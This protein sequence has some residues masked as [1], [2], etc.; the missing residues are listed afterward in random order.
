MSAE[1]SNIALA[2]AVAAAGLMADPA[3]AG[4]SSRK[5]TSNCRPTRLSKATPSIGTLAL[6][7]DRSSSAVVG[8]TQEL[9]NRDVTEH[10]ASS[11]H[12]G[13]STALMPMRW[14]VGTPSR[15]SRR[16]V[17]SRNRQSGVRGLKP[18]CS[19]VTKA[20]AMPSAEMLRA[21]SPTAEVAN[22]AAEVARVLADTLSGGG[23]HRQSIASL[24]DALPRAAQPVS[25][26]LA[27][28]FAPPLGRR[29]AT[30]LRRSIQRILSS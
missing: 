12:P 18:Q 13:M 16:R 7:R 25:E 17:A 27:S 2:S 5:W 26:A 1:N 11:A 10:M 9:A 8:G 19:L 4:S 24:L 6:P 15:P 3:A 21:A 23:D 14:P 20:I 29:L 22:T 30:F 28:Q